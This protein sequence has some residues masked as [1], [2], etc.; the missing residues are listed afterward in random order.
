VAETVRGPAVVGIFKSIDLPTNEPLFW[1][2]PVVGSTKYAKEPPV[3][4]VFW[5]VVLPVGSQFGSS[6]GFT[7]ANWI[8]VCVVLPDGLSAVAVLPM[9]MRTHKYADY[10]DLDAINSG[11]LRQIQALL[12]TDV[13]A[14][15][16]GS[17]QRAAAGV[18]AQSLAIVNRHDHLVNSLP[19][20]E[21]AKLLHA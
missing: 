16:G 11:T 19:A 8:G 18:R 3:Q 13:A 4:F 2:A 15:F 12:S 6:Q 7:P 1:N 9:T 17:L 20:S 5:G 14:S 10:Y 21:F